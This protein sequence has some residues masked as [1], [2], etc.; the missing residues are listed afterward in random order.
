M[1]RKKH[2]ILALCVLTISLLV[3]F[4]I[5]SYHEK[6][7]TIFSS[8]KKFTLNWVGAFGANIAWPLIALFGI[9]AYGMAATGLWASWRLFKGP[10]FERAWLRSRESRF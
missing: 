5:L 9:G 6:D 3:L 4:S 10:S 8:S 1:N 7:P 2:E